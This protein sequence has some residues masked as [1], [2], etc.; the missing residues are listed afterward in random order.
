[1]TRVDRQIAFIERA[2]REK[3]GP[4][5]TPDLPAETNP[6]SL[7]DWHAHKEDARF[8]YDF[9]DGFEYSDGREV[10]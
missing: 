1:M 7:S 5:P 3:N 10:S 8:Y 6:I 4:I 2:W 9:P